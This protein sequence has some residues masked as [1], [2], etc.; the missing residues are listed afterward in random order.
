MTLTDGTGDGRPGRAAATLLIVALSGAAACLGPPDRNQ[1]TAEIDGEE[2]TPVVV[3]TSQNFAVGRTQGDTA[4][5]S[6][7]SADTAEVEVPWEQTFDISFSQRFFIRVTAGEEL[8]KDTARAST[9]GLR[10]SIDG[11]EQFDVS[12]DLLTRPLQFTFASQSQR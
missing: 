5:V 4:G 12:A 9:V 2:G 3:V 1:A 8:R 10:V 6:L 7:L 11:N